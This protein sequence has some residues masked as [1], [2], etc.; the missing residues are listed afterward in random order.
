L[1]EPIPPVDPTDPDISAL[2]K[3]VSDLTAYLEALTS[4]TEARQRHYSADLERLS[5]EV[6]AAK[7]DAAAKSEALLAD[8]ERVV[9]NLISEQMAELNALTSHTQKVDHN[10]GNWSKIFSEIANVESE[11]EE[12]DVQLQLT[13]AHS[14][15]EE[16]TLE[17]DSMAKE[18][19]LREAALA[20]ALELRVEAVTNELTQLAAEERHLRQ[21][22]EI[23]LADARRSLE[24]IITIHA[25]GLRKL[26]EGIA[27]QNQALASR[28]SLAKAQLE[29]ERRCVEMEEAAFNAS[30]DS[31]SKAKRATVK[32]YTEQLEA[33][34]GQITKLSEVLAAQQSGEAE[35]E[36]ATRASIT[37]TDALTRENAAL[38]QKVKALEEELAVRRTQVR[39]ATRVLS[40]ARSPTKKEASDDS[41]HAS[42]E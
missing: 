8:Q 1:R 13:R 19:A 24:G 21:Q 28:L 12:A 15:Q 32:R 34:Q 7:S 11:L 2:E 29:R 26:R 35:D 42:L 40:G 22:H 14:K 27:R 37:K 5:A 25:S 23:V 31:L 33:G 18:H 3:Q 38:E 41:L 6:E 4:H 30:I 16:L 36:A 10:C 17:R 9:Q 39:T 20:A